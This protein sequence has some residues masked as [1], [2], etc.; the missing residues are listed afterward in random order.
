MIDSVAKWNAISDN[1]ILMSKH[2]KLNSNIIF[3]T[4]TNDETVP[5]GSTT[6]PFIGFLKETIIILFTVLL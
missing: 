3:P 2:F 6:H 5:I 1:P 4:T